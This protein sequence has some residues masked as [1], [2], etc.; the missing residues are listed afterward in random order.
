MIVEELVEIVICP[1]CKTKTEHPY[2][3]QPNGLFGNTIR[4]QNI[5]TCGKTF[6]VTS[7][8]VRDKKENII[9]ALSR[10][11]LDNEQTTLAEFYDHIA[12]PTDL[13]D[14]TSLEVIK[15]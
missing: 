3:K 12:N 13:Q 14:D 4:C 7:A 11:G 10:R 6:F 9:D 5:L 15:K 2:R 8:L 1:H